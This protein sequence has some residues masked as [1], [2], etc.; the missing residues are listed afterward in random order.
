MPLVGARRAIYGVI[1]GDRLIA[2]KG[3]M[4]AVSGAIE[5]Y[6]LGNGTAGVWSQVVVISGSK[7]GCTSLSDK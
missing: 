3:T 1:Y 6:E 4:L 2:I 5:V 7:H